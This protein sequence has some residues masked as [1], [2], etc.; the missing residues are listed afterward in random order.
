MIISSEKYIGSF[1]SHKLLGTS[2][3]ARY[4]QVS[5]VVPF[6]PHPFG[7]KRS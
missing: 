4:A 7:F 2:K 6:I 3:V 1:M 5:H